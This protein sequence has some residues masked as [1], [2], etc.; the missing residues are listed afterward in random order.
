[1]RKN[2]SELKREPSARGPQDNSQLLLTILSLWHQFC[3]L[4]SQN[5]CFTSLLSFQQ[6]T[7]THTP[8][9]GEAHGLK[10]G[11]GGSVDDKQNLVGRRR[12]CSRWYAAI[13]QPLM[14]PICLIRV[15]HFHPHTPLPSQHTRSLD[16]L[17]RVI[18]TRT[19]TVGER[20]AG[21]DGGEQDP[22]PQTKLR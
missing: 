8:L 17:L 5:N 3:S 15:V 11:V 4:H 18:Y 12:T 21:R 10:N 9:M 13:P 6:E 7:L 1:M 16:P 2:R 22:P 14:R 19:V 20:E